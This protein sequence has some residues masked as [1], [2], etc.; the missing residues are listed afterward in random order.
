MRCLRILLVLSLYISGSLY[1]IEETIQEETVTWEMIFDEIVKR[2]KSDLKE[3][4]LPTTK[5]EL[6]DHVKEKIAEKEEK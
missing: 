1:S 6:Y 5:Q 3:M 4:G 2:S